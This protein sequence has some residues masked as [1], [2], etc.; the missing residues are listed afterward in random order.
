M[1]KPKMGI[2]VVLTMT[3]GGLFVTWQQYQA[4]A[5]LREERAAFGDA[6]GE[7]ARLR[8]E[9]RRLA[10][11]AAEAESYRG[12]VAELERLKREA[13]ALVERAQAAKRERELA[14]QSAAAAVGAAKIYNPAEVDQLP[15]TQARVRPTYPFDLRRAGVTGQAIVS[16]VVNADGEIQD[17]QGVSSTHPEFEASAIDA[18]KKWKFTAAQKAGLAVGVR[19]QVPI[20]FS[21]SQ[22]KQ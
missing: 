20:V 4:N 12:D 13:G 8:E 15:V 17:V 9:N 19:M 10:E 16:F 7:I 2:I 18:V 1:N 6:N 5:R 11:T 22:E 21:L 3:G 14:A